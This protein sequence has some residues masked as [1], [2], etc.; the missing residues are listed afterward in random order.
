LKIVALKDFYWPVGTH[1][2]GPLHG[3]KNRTEFVYKVQ[4]PMNGMLVV[5]EAVST[6]QGWVEG[7]LESVE[8]ALTKKWITH[9]CS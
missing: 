6:Y 1:Y 9:G 2:Y 8:T 5:G 3:V 4:H 7:A